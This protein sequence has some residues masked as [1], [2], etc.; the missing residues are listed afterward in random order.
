MWLCITLL[1]SMSL[2]TLS[3]PKYDHLL[4]SSGEKKEK[5]GKK[6]RVVE[7][8]LTEQDNSFSRLCL[9]EVTNI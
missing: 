3:H 6:I 9:D 7:H 2:L 5:K 8:H 1:L 4:L